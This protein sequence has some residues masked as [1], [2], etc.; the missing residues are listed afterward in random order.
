MKQLFPLYLSFV[1]NVSNM[2]LSPGSVPNGSL[3]SSA[4]AF[5]PFSQAS[6]V[7]YSEGLIPGSSPAYC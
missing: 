2:D 7:E 1:L 6:D 5:C 4:F 3:Y